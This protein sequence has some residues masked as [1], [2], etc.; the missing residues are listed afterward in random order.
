[1]LLETVAV[2]SSESLS[3]TPISSGTSLF[4]SDLAFPCQGSF[5]AACLE[6]SGH[7][8]FVRY[9]IVSL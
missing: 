1:M 7:A 4:H 2:T 9:D 8:Y 3:D 6:A 5:E